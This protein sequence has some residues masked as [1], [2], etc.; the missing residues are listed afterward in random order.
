MAVWWYGGHMK[1]VTFT[2]DD[3]T[4]ERLKTIAADHG[5]DLAQ[6]ALAWV[7]N[8]KGITSIV[9]GATSMEQLDQNL[10]A[11]SIR[12]SQEEIEACDEVWHTLHPPRLFYGR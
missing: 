1:K 4:V 6:F 10:A 2:L 3:E 12:L 7:L 9:C 8:K 11:V 5:K